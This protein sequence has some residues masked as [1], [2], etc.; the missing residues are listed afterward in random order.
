[1]TE[2]AW[3]L[4]PRWA[5]F[6]LDAAL[7]KA[8]GET[9]RACNDADMQGLGVVR[10]NGVELV[11]TLGNRLRIRAAS[12]TGASSPTSSSPIT[13]AWRDRTYEEELG[14]KALEKAGRRSGTAGF[15]RRSRPSRQLFNYDRAL[16]RRRKREEDHDRSAAARRAVSNIA[17]LLGGIALWNG[18]EH[19]YGVR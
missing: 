12:W 16:H 11:I 14:L 4:H 1:M 18:K 13:P 9:V 3:N 19:D 5:G 8:L 6:D 17:G 10:G 2:T 7:T 15:A